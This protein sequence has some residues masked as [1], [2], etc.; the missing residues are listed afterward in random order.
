MTPSVGTNFFALVRTAANPVRRIKLARDV[1]QTLSELFVQAASQMLHED[2]EHVPF[3]GSYRPDESEILVINDFK[4][5]TEIWSAL[6]EP[7]SCDDLDLGSRELPNIRAIFTGETGEKPWVAL[8][9]FQRNQF[10]TRRGISIVLS[11]D[12]F[13]RLEAPGL[14][15]G[16][17]VDAHFQDNKLFFQSFYAARRVL[18][19]NEYYREATD[20]DVESFASLPSVS[21]SHPASLQRN[22]DS[23][24]RRK[25][26]LIQ[27][28]GILSEHTPIA[29]HKAAADYGL[30]VE[31]QGE[32]DQAVLVFPDSKKSLKS[33]LKFLD[34]DYYSGPVTGAKYLS[35]SKR[36]VS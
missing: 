33:L 2:I 30:S 14:S 16:E 1:Q 28:R 3:Q 26:A 9:A 12:T 4:V 36:T 25:I 23:W 15:I 13:R 24:V 18:D 20:R 21:F 17:D 5:P 31:V 7:T 34:E 6:K 29:I 27:D 19:L 22:A 35:N 10:L 8:Q 11:G 32:G